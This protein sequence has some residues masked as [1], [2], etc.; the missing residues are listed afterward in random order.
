MKCYPLDITTFI[1]CPQ[2]LKKAAVNHKNATR[3]ICFEFKR[4]LFKAMSHNVFKN[5]RVRDCCSYFFFFFFSTVVIL[6]GTIG[7]FIS[8]IRKELRFCC[9]S[10]THV[11]DN[12]NM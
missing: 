3:V 2:G 1:E 10:T 6:L 5:Q 7:Q 4:M 8:H 12:S 9:F 11:P